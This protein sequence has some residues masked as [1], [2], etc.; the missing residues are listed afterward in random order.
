MCGNPDHPKPLFVSG[1]TR[2]GGRKEKRKLFNLAIL[3]V[4]KWHRAQAQRSVERRKKSAIL[5]GHEIRDPTFHAWLTIGQEFT[6]IARKLPEKALK[7][8][9]LFMRNETSKSFFSSLNDDFSCSNFHS[10]WE[11]TEKGGHRR[12]SLNEEMFASVV[13]EKEVWFFLNDSFHP[14]FFSQKNTKM[15][16]E[17]PA[18]KFTSINWEIINLCGPLMTQCKMQYS[19]LI[20]KRKPIAR[21][22]SLLLSSPSFFWVLSGPKFKFNG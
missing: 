15:D 8:G 11:M 14:C 7:L 10:D 22:V 5:S 19:L 3:A 12:S 1:V 6:F 13:K 17:T 18:E 20:S 21:K 2:V 9:G 16:A 4:L